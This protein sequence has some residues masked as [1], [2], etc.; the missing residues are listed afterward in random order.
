MKVLARRIVDN[1]DFTSMRPVTAY[2]AA[3]AAIIET[4]ELIA[5]WLEQYPSPMN[6]LGMAM[7][8]REICAAIRSGQQFRKDV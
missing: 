4:Q 8:I 3:Y 5:A 6:D 1:L 2:D 7:R